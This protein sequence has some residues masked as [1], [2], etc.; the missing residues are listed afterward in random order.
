[1]LSGTVSVNFQYSPL[2]RLR[3]QTKACLLQMLGNQLMTRKL[4]YFCIADSAPYQT[5]KMA[6]K[7]LLQL[8]K[9]DIIHII[10]SGEKESSVP[11]LHVV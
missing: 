7:L 11:L 5:L 6:V 1:M 8:V 10:P 3:P 2:L 9:V 4:H